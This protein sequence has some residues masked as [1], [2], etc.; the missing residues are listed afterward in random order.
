MYN[1]MHEVVFLQ[2]AVFWLVSQY[3]LERALS[4]GAHIAPSSRL[5]NKKSKKLVVA[6]N[7]LATCNC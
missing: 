4:F 2:A 1:I 6:G 3:S 5:E 7:Q